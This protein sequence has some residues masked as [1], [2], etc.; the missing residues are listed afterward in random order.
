MADQTKTL[1]KDENCDLFVDANGNIAIAVGIDAYAQIVNSK[2][3]TVLGELPMDVNGGLPY[4]QTI[5]KDSSM[6]DVFEAEAIKMLEGIDFVSSVKSFTCE[7]R[8]DVLYYTAEIVTDKGAMT[9]N[10]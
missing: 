6:V 9:V 4:F 5:F 8:G 3:R 2:M 10:G 1:A 7:V